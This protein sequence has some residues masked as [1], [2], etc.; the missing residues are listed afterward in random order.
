MVQLPPDRL[1]L[2]TRSNYTQY[3]AS[4]H[5][6]IYIYIYILPESINSLRDIQLF[7]ASAVT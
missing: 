7:F 6:Y 4:A 1:T 5:A 3:K 2:Y